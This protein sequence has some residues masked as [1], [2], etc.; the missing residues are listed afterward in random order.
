MFLQKGPS[1]GF[2][3]SGQ[4]GIAGVAIYFRRIWQ[5]CN[6]QVAGIRPVASESAIAKS[7]RI[8]RQARCCEAA[9]VCG[10]TGR[11]CE[12]GRGFKG[13]GGKLQISR[14]EPF[15]LSQRPEDLPFLLRQHLAT[16]VQRTLQNRASGMLK[17]PP[18]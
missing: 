15:S 1:G 3:V 8:L 7:S 9:Q 16:S 11:A 12:F 6:R 10:I 5:L 14:F 13:S 18:C 2:H 4:E 17:C